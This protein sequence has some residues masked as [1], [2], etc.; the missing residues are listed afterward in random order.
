MVVMRI[1]F[2]DL[3]EKNRLNVTVDVCVGVLY[4]LPEDALLLPLG[5]PPLNKR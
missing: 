2:L 5:P 4:G 3:L 1:R